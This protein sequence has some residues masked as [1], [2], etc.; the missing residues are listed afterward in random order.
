MPCLVYQNSLKW[1]YDAVAAFLSESRTRKPNPERIESR[2]SSLGLCLLSHRVLIPV[3]LLW[4][5]LTLEQTLQT[6]AHFSTL[7]LS[8]LLRRSRPQRAISADVAKNEVL[9]AFMCHLHYN[10]VD[11]R[12]VHTFRFRERNALR[13]RKRERAH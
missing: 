9:V 3:G 6:L 13:S 1:G 2:L 10:T 7:L 4:R 12:R 5:L 11:V 8:S